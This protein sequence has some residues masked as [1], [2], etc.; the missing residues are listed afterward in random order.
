MSLLNTPFYH[1]ML[2]KYHIAFG[3]CF[4]NLTLLR[5]DLQGNELQR[6]VVPIEYVPRES[7]L[8]R[9]RSDPDISSKVSN[10]WPKLAF[11]MTGMRYDPT[12]RLNSLS[13]RLRSNGTMNTMA[14]YFAG[15]PYILSFSLYGIMRSVE[16]LNQI[17]EQIV[18]YFAIDYTMTINALPSMGIQDQM[19]IVMDGQP[20]WTD[21]FEADNFTRTREIVLT[22]NFS[23]GVMLYGPINT[24][25]ANIIRSVMVDL[26]D[27]SINTTLA[28]PSY[29]MTNGFDLLELEDLS[30]RLLDESSVTDPR[31]LT[32]AVEI[33]IVPN[34]ADAV[35]PKP[36]DSTTTITDYFEGS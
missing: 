28:G 15:A 13:P 10:V 8:T 4:S 1:Q 9:L 6:V 34:P 21:S 19:R 30:G 12:R 22:M 2:R 31:E 27:A 32:K 17:I 33:T 18:P 23:V 20:T 24:T 14:K 36:V 16:D 7:W 26:Y 29:L 35:P 25:P 11:E 3:S 5:D